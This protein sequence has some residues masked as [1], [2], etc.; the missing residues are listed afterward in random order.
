MKTSPSAS[1]TPDTT[2]YQ[3][4]RRNW[5]RSWQVACTRAALHPNA[6]CNVAQAA[7][8]VSRIRAVRRVLEIALQYAPHEF[9]ATS[10]KYLVERPVKVLYETIDHQ[11]AATA[12]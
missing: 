1:I 3:Y 4:R 5:R 12:G 9:S 7:M 11:V 2:I 10:T 6:E 8:N